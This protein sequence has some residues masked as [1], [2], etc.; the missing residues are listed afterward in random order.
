MTNF[1]D[2]GNG[3]LQMSFG[4]L[5]GV[6][7]Y[8]CYETGEL[9]N[10]RLGERNMLLTHAGELIPAYTET[11]R[12]KRKPSLEFYKNGLT[13]S[14]C[15]E[16]QQ[17][18]V[19]PIGEFPAEFLTF[20]ETGEL[21]RFFPLDGQMS[22]FWSL[23]EE[24][25]LNF[26][27][28]FDLGW[29]EFTTLLG[30]ICLY[31][32]GAIRSVTLFPGETLRLPSPAGE[33]LTGVGFSLHESGAL[34]SAEPASPLPVVTPVGNLEAFDPTAAGVN[35]DRSSLRFDAPILGCQCGCIWVW[36]RSTILNRLAVASIS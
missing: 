28:T 13:R 10:V 5:G 15:L 3:N 7:G 14:V 2:L 34:A 18:I 24:R 23:E 16:E 36:N 8:E 11:V 20:Y 4:I 33:L 29:G 27:L 1:T 26:P 19:T 22:G 30:G 9:Q 6:T 25:E 31:P 21:K 12:R 32:S 17:E 35:A